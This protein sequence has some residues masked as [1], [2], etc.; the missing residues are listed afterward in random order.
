MPKLVGPAQPACTRATSD[1]FRCEKQAT[2]RT[3][4]ECRS[5]FSHAR[6]HSSEPAQFFNWATFTVFTPNY[7]V[8]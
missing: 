1:N 5:N 6:G 4:T 3:T 2:Q 7:G 8:T